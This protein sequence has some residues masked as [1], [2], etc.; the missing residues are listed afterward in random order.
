MDWNRAYA[1]ADFIPEGAD[2][3]AR[4]AAAAEAFR[5][6]AKARLDLPYGDGPRNRFD[7]F[8]PEG[9]PKGLALFIHGG[10]WMAFGR[11]IWSHLAAGPHKDLSR[12]V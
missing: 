5:A 3:P 7:L 9:T 6:G 1:N 8:L 4:W 10:Y 2:Y 11:E 12:G